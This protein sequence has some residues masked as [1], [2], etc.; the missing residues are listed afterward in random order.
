MTHAFKKALEL[1]LSRRTS[2]RLSQ[3]IV[4]AR[5]L[6]LNTSQ[7]SNITSSDSYEPNRLGNQN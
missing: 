7:P 4:D 3:E 2:S 5:N 1:P 6:N